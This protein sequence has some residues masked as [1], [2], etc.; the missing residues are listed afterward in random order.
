MPASGQTRAPHF[1]SSTLTV[2]PSASSIS[3]TAYRPQS[4]MMSGPDP[5]AKAAAATSVSA[6]ESKVRQDWHSEPSAG[7][8]TPLAHPARSAIPPPQTRAPGISHT[9]I[10]SGSPMPS[11]D[12]W[13]SCCAHLNK[14]ANRK[15]PDDETCS[16]WLWWTPATDPPAAIEQNLRRKSSTNAGSHNTAPLPPRS[17]TVHGSDNRPWQSA[18]KTAN[19]FCVLNRSR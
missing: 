16:L 14:I 18:A 11:S 2:L 1:A 6:G 5:L 9:G 19:C 10:P 3:Q 13:P 17:G 12:P 15:S 8:T 4:G 7:Q